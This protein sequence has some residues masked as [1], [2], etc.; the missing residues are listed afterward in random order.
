MKQ[1]LRRPRRRARASLARKLA[2]ARPARLDPDAPP[3]VSWPPASHFTQ[4]PRTPV[5]TSRPHRNTLADRHAKPGRPVSGGRPPQPPRPSTL[6]HKVLAATSAAVA[7]SAVLTL[8]VISG[9]SHAQQPGRPAVSGHNRGTHPSD[10]LIRFQPLPLISPWHGNVEYGIQDGVVYLTGFAVLDTG[11]GTAITVLPWSIR[12]RSQ[13]DIP[14][15][16]TPL[17]A[18]T[19]QITPNG[20][21]R[22]LA[23]P[24]LLHTS[25]IWLSGVKFPL[26]S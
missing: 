15:A 2:S 14:I 17:A 22:T 21:V 10:T 18:L 19:L 20:L 25:R 4:L 3:S 11:S 1:S 8:A 24:K 9:G 13:L 7:I 16:A 12:P 26:R 6:R 5:A 23:V